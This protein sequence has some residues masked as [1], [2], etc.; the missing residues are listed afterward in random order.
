MAQQGEPRPYSTMADQLH[1]SLIK[2]LDAMSYKT[3]TPVQQ[4]VLMS[5]PSFT[6]DCLVQAKTGTGKTTAFLLPILSSLISSRLL[7]RG[8]VSALILSPT[9][10]LA[11]QIAAECTHLTQFMTPKPEVH[12]AFG[13]T[14]RAKNLKAFLGGNP[15]ILVATPGRLKD[16]L[17]EDETR[18]RFG[19]VRTV[20]LDEADTMLE[21]G[22][23]RDVKAIL[24]LLPPKVSPTNGTLNWQGMCFSAT[25]PQNIMPVIN[26]VLRKG[27]THLTTIAASEN[28]THDRVPQFH[29]LIPSVV[30]TIPALLSLLTHE[31]SM[32][33]NS[34]A[35]ASPEHKII[36][37]G[38][39]ANLVALYTA[40][41]RQSPLATK[42]PAFELHSRMSQPARTKTTDA[43]KTAGVGVLFATD[44]I[45]RG[46]DFPYVTAVL[47]VGLPMNGE[48]Y[49]H[50]VG[51]TARAERD[52]R[53]V[54]LL[55]D[56][57][58]FFLKTNPQLTIERYSTTDAINADQWAQR[59]AEQC[60]QDMDNVTKAKAYS[61]YL[62]FMKGFMNKL[63]LSPAAL[64]QTAN[65][66]VLDGMGCAEI[67][68]LEKSTVSK[69]GLKGVPGLRF[70]APGTLGGGRSNVGSYG[71][72]RGAGGNSARRD[73]FEA[74]EGGQMSR[75]HHPIDDG[76]R[77][78]SGGDR[79][80][81]RGNRGKG[82]G[83]RGG[84]GRGG[85]I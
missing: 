85:A 33:A 75:K 54:L 11:L 81:P 19:H 51:R 37:F 59:L 1:P 40:V 56:M 27:Y 32:D 58:A 62:G 68:A 29:V 72:G 28:L 38:T 14:A 61:A 22:F 7:P 24:A 18:R 76:N 64:V 42:Y 66:F 46:M 44:V 65:D 57:E 31:L 20:V 67:P 69:M 63:R 80:R 10:E 8:Q 73:Q 30:Q 71:G 70:A 3:M 49:V 83:G 60:L 2:A 17:S 21:Q 9:R 43:F 52:G 50:R 25:I 34:A 23:I 5:L 4:K 35:A 15:T 6:A 78:G 39:T 41:Y 74:S 77:G 26:T 12:T 84:G 47:Q 36:V 16:Y 45:G 79:K 48:Q 82:R 13:G 53:A 55:T